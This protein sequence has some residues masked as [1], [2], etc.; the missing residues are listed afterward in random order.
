M[1]RL[2]ALLPLAFVLGS[3]PYRSPVPTLQR[4]PSRLS[5][6]EIAEITT[7]ASSVTLKGFCFAESSL[8]TNLKHSDPF[9]RGWFGLH[10]TPAI[11][12][13]RA[14]MY[15]EYDAD[16]PTQAAYIAGRNYM[17]NLS[18]LGREDWAIAAHKQGPTGVRRDGVDR[19]YVAKVRAGR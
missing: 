5:C 4:V 11:H 16:N 17:D 15:G 9:D 14:R 13:E 3:A 19:E 1:T 10:E 2:L 7:G 18:I 6:Y 12:A 8:G